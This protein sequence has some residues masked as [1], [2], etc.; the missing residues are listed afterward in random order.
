MF[1]DFFQKATTRQYNDIIFLL[2]GGEAQPF[3]YLSYRQ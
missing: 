1:R 3:I 2:Y